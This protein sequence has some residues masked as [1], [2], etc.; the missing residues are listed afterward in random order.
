MFGGEAFD[1]RGTVVGR[2]IID[3]NDLVR[4]SGLF[5]DAVNCFF[6]KFGAVVERNHRRDRHLHLRAYRKEIVFPEVYTD[7]GRAKLVFR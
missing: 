7:I 6:N 5:E 3:N 2:S 4:R 1:F